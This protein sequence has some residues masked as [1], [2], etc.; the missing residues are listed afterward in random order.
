MEVARSC[1]FFASPIF[2]LT[3]Y[4]TTQIQITMF[5]GGSDVSLMRFP[6]HLSAR[7]R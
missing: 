2:F 6:D 3:K 4:D 7:S 1:N 5:Q